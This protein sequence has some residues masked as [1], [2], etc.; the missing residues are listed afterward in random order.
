MVSACRL[1]AKD[2]QDKQTCSDLDADQT[3]VRD[4]RYRVSDC[5]DL[6]PASPMSAPAVAKQTPRTLPRL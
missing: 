3:C 2:V 6:V 5:Q 1:A 4:W